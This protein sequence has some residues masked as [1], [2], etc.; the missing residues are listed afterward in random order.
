MV[1]SQF[2]TNWKNFCFFF[3][4]W[5]EILELKFVIDQNRLGNLN[6]TVFTVRYHVSIWFSLV[7]Y[8]FTHFCLRKIRI[9]KLQI[10][11]LKRRFIGLSLKTK[12]KFLWYLQM[13]MAKSLVLKTCWFVDHTHWYFPAYVF[14]L[15]L[16]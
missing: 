11:L 8:K 2:N 13:P 7:P 6:Y 1:L 4:L 14:T 3:H 10:R 5:M 9:H 12:S 16:I 15:V